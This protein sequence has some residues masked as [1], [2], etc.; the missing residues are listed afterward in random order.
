[1][2]TYN[3][4]NVIASVSTF[5]NYRADFFGKDVDEALKHKKTLKGKSI[6]SDEDEPV[7]GNE[8]VLIPFHAVIGYALVMSKTTET[9][10]DAYCK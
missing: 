8:T 1:M 3:K 7:Y 5:G 9:K 4:P 10:E 6:T 2:Q